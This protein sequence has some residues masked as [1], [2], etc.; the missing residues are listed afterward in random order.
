MF[1]NE[2]WINDLCVFLLEVK[3]EDWEVIIVG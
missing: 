2:E 1:L 3:D